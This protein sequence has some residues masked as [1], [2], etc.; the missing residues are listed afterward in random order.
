[1]DPRRN[2]GDWGI[3]LLIVGLL[4]LGLAAC[5][6]SPTQQAADALRATAPAPG[7][8]GD[9]GVKPTASA[10]G[11]DDQTPSAAPE[12][13]AAA[14]PTAVPKAEPLKV[15]DKGFGQDKQEVAYAFLI[16]NP[17]QGLAVERSKY[18]VA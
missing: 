7:A 5:G 6:G 2:T 17:N 14:A 12:A 1:M 13:T 9:T 4:V 16:E 10:P 18:Q 3:L 15:N 8:S 11:G